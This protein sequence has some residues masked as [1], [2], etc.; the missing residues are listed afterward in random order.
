MPDSKQIDATLRRLATEQASRDYDLGRAMLAAERDRTHEQWAFR[1]ALEYLEYRLPD[2]KPSSITE[3]LRVARRL[4][5][6]PMLA[7]AL[8]SGRLAFS[9]VREITRIAAGEG[10]GGGG[11]PAMCNAR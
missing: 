11:G 5:E 1:S 10:S 9:I 2:L 3:R 6:L 8:Q 4:E 7:D